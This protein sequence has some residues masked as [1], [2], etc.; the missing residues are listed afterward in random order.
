MKFKKGDLVKF[1]DEAGHGEVLSVGENGIVVRTEDDFEQTYHAHELIPYKTFEVGEASRKDA[2]IKPKSPIKMPPKASYLEQDLHI[3]SLVDFTGGMSNF[4]MLRTQLYT[5]KNTIAK[6]RQAGIKKVILIHGIGEGI[7][8]QE[9]YK[10]LDAHERI[11]YYD[12][13][14]AKY[15]KGATEVILL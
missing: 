4:D 11:T 7:L 1:I 12:A 5:A 6:A 2:A 3:G 9:L 15:G 14:Y 10:L 13:D 8:R